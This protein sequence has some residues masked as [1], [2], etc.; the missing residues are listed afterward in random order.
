MQTKKFFGQNEK[1]SDRLQNHSVT[2]VLT[3]D[4]SFSIENN[5]NV[6]FRLLINL[7]NIGRSAPPKSFNQLRQE[8][9]TRF[10][11]TNS[12]IVEVNKAKYPKNNAVKQKCHGTVKL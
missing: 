3:K 9:I 7:L 1:I 11:I 10:I 2:L 6:L 5:F 8:R 4:T 12:S